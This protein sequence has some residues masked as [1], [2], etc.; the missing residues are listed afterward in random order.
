MLSTGRK[1]ENGIRR[2]KLVSARLPFSREE[3]EQGIESDLLSNRWKTHR[4]CAFSKN[5][6]SSCVY[7]KKRDRKK[8]Q[9]V[10][11]I[12]NG[13]HFLRGLD[14]L[15]MVEVQQLSESL[16]GGEAM[17]SSNNPYPPSS[18][19]LSSPLITGFGNLKLSSERCRNRFHRKFKN[20]GKDRRVA[21][22]P[23][24]KR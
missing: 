21:T 24:K 1:R 4:V 8:E 20:D 16:E 22:L 17:G 18:A 14:L 23:T 12:E 2:G 13:C 7:T 3:E 11:P 6:E 15:H 19:H 5:N 9:R 10:H